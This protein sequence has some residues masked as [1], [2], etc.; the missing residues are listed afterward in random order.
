MHADD[1]CLLALLGSPSCIAKLVKSVGS[2]HS[3]AG[4]VRVA[5]YHSTLLACIVDSFWQCSHVVMQLS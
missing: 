1:I 3:A 4:L 2:V 5:A